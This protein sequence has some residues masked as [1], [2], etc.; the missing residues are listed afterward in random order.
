MT[1]DLNPYP[2]YKPSNV[3]KYRKIGAFWVLAQV[4]EHPMGPVKLPDGRLQVLRP[5]SRYGVAFIPVPAT[6][7][8][9][10]GQRVRNS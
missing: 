5:G 10:A 3:E 2:I 4:A 6:R 9:M 8:A 7:Q 1:A